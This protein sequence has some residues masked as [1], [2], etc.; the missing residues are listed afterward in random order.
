MAHDLQVQEI[1]VRPLTLRYLI[2]QLLP[3]GTRNM[4]ALLG[5][6]LVLHAAWATPVATN[7]N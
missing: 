5:V 1:H 4:W 6:M 2:V 3:C 7:R